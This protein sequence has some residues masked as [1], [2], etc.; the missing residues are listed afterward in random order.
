MLSFAGR[1]TVMALRLVSVVVL[2]RLLTPE[3]FGAF[4]AAAAL[5]ALGTVAT[6]LGVHQYLVRAPALTLA[7]R[8][9]ALGLGLAVALPVMAVILGLCAWLPPSWMAPEL[10]GAL[11]VLALA[12]LPQ[13]FAAVAN[14][15]L[16]RE[17]RFGPIY[18]IGLAG[19]ATLVLAS[20]GLALLGLGA[21]GLAWATLAE[22]C[23]ATLLSH[24]WEPLVPPSFSGWRPLLVFV[25]S[26]IAITGL[27]QAG[28]SLVRLSIGALLG[29]HAV[30]LLSRAQA[31][32]HIFDRALLD[33]V[34][35]VVLPTVAARQRAG[36]ELAPVYLRQV[37]YLAALA[38]PFCGAVALL[39]DPLV[40]LL[41][42]PQW[43]GAVPAVRILAAAGFFLPLSGMV[44]SYLVALGA[45]RRYVPIQLA[46]QAGKAALVAAGALVS[47]ELA[48]AALVVEAAARAVLAQRLLQEVLH[49]SRREL[50][51]LLGLSAGPTLACLA[52]TA[53]VALPLEA[54][55]APA[56]LV[57]T[58]AAAAGGLCWLAALFALRHPLREEIARLR[59]AVAARLSRPR[60]PPAARDQAAPPFAHISPKRRSHSGGSYRSNPAA[61][62]RTS[63]ESRSRPWVQ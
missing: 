10:R 29:L 49:H 17:M 28:D 12:L 41:L 48:C 57:L 33:A 11:A 16:Y 43:S 35:P 3:E 46:L 32:V 36:G 37:A 31:V 26:W 50:L 19:A 58:P 23:V 21:V 15:A 39:A 47:L 54:R 63:S 45:E 9:A 52:A 62:V 5:A 51:R 8:R 27:R 42:G 59:A 4:A 6:D 14:G 60:P 55:E 7:A 20:I 40:R 61:G 1:Y 56:W 13:P 25:R 53:A 18:W 38:W 30:G 22:I 34:G 24:R 44:L 2:A